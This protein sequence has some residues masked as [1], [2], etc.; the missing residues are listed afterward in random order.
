MTLFFSI[1]NMQ[2]GTKTG[3]KSARKFPDLD[4][5]MSKCTDAPVSM[6]LGYTRPAQ[7]KIK[8]KQFSMQ[9]YEAAGSRKRR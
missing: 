6:V 1:Y 8:M 7:A 3:D 5:Q 9:K 2:L 4:R